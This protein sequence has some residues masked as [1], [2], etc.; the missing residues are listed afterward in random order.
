MI[1]KICLLTLIG[2]AAW[3]ET[4]LTVG[5]GTSYDL[6][7]V[8]TCDCWSVR[9]FVTPAAA[10]AS[11][12]INAVVLGASMGAQS[13]AD[14]VLEMPRAV[15]A[16]N[17]LVAFDFSTGRGAKPQHAVFDVIVEFQSEKATQRQTLQLTVPAA[18]LRPPPTLLIQRAVPF[19]WFKGEDFMPPLVL[20]PS[21]KSRAPAWVTIAKEGRFSDAEGDHSGE[22]FFN[23]S[24]K[25]VPRDSSQEFTYKTSGEFPLGTVK[26]NLMISSRQL[27]SPLMVPVEVRTKRVKAVLWCLIVA[28]L[29]LGFVLRTWLKQQLQYADLKQQALDSLQQIGI[30]A[31]KE[32]DGKFREKLKAAAVDLEAVI[33]RASRR[34]QQD[35]TDAV[36]TART[37]VNDAKADLTDRL[38]K[39]QA[40]VQDF[41]TLTATHWRT[42]SA[43]STGLMQ[44]AKVIPAI[45]VALSQNDEARAS[46]LL[47]K[48]GE[49]LRGFLLTAIP[50]WRKSWTAVLG[51]MKA[52]AQVM[53]DPDREIMLKRVADLQA[54]LDQSPQPSAETPLTEYLAD[55]RTIDAMTGGAISP[56]DTAAAAV[57]NAWDAINTEL[58]K[59][60][61]LP[62]LAAWQATKAPTDEYA[63]ALNK[64]SPHLTSDLMLDIAT[65][66]SQLKTL[67][68]NALLAQIADAEK[69]ALRALIDKGQF[70]EAAERIPDRPVAPADAIQGPT[71]HTPDA[72]VA[73]PVVR[74]GLI[75][76]NLRTETERVEE[77]T[78]P[79]VSVNRLN[80][81]SDFRRLRRLTIKE[82]FIAQSAQFV[83]SAIG[84]AIVG[85]LLFSDKFVGT[86]PEMLTAFFWGFTTD[87]GLDALITAAKGKA[88]A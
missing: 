27:E 23:S 26:A 16:G 58:E 14:L 76:L 17:E 46:A 34:N 41:T 37:A 29:L 32:H 68:S 5:R 12:T 3:G 64:A 55:L 6:S 82:R 67:W 22:L 66:G 83:I 8:Q 63:E 4:L 28:G 19:L 75:L 51:Q 85:Y 30:E 73:A 50:E 81:A 11:K 45:N 33:V 49:Q 65:V 13:P 31:A 35:L 24:E 60:S 69:P 38:A 74:A 87:V 1:G 18:V 61:R 77:I 79:D 62:N 10:Y 20:V 48:E 52:S 88:S 71:W 9:V 78:T 36:N 2:I 25:P 80:S 56:L 7:Y 44:A 72:G 39:A 42:S 43:I 86:G 47:E 57:E 59:K 54:R 53:I 21:E 70:V 84:L 15:K 40:K